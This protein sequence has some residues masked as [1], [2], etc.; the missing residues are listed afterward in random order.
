MELSFTDTSAD[1]EDKFDVIRLMKQTLPAHVVKS[2][3]AAG[4]DSK[5]V[6]A[7]MDVSSKKGNSITEIESSLKDPF[8]MIILCV[9]HF[10]HQNI[11]MNF[12]LDTE[13][14]YAILC[15]K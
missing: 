12:L 6:L 9:V 4:Y 11:H 13:Y 14:V 2:F 8:L 7:S 10:H 15:K 3:L 5:E 1:T